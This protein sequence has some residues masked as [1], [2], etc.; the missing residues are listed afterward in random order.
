MKALMHK[1]V[2]AS[3][4]VA[5]LLALFGEQTEGA[6][7]PKA[8]PTPAAQSASRSAIPTMAV[9]SETNPKFAETFAD[10]KLNPEFAR[11]YPNPTQRVKAAQTVADQICKDFIVNASGG[12]DAQ[13]CYLDLTIT[14]TYTYD[15]SS[16][17]PAYLYHGIYIEMCPGMQITAPPQ[18][19]PATGAPWSAW[20][21][22]ATFGSNPAGS[23][24]WN[25]IWWTRPVNLFNNIIPSGQPLSLRLRIPNFCT[26]SSCTFKVQELTGFWAYPNNT[27]GWSCERDFTIPVISSPYSIGPDISVC[28]GEA[29]T[30]CIPNV[31]TGA[32]VTWYA[33]PPQGSPLSC[34]PANCSASTL[35]APWQVAQTGTSNCFNTNILT[36]SQCY[37]AVVNSGCIV[38]NTNVKRIDVCPGPPNASIGATPDTSVPA[39]TVINGVNHACTSWKGTLCLNPFT[40]P[41]PTTI[42]W[43]VNGN[44]IVI[45]P[46]FK[47]FCIPTGLLTAT[48]CSTPYTFQALLHNACGD[49]PVTWTIVIDKPPIPGAI[50]ANPPPPLCYDRATMLTLPPT[51]GQVVQWE[52]REELSPCSGNYGPWVAISGSQGTWTWWTN[53]LQK[54]TQYRVL[55]ENGACRNPPNP[56][57]YSQ[58]KIVTVKPPL[59][60][61]ITANKTVLCPPGGVILTAHSS[62]GPPCAYAVTYQWFKNGVFTG[63]TGATYSPTTGGNYYVVVNGQACGTA[64]SNV[65]TICD[66]PKL[67]ITG[68]CCVC[69]GETITLTANVLSTPQGCQVSCNN[70]TWNTGATG[71][72]IP[73]S[74]PGTYTVTANCGGCQLSASFTVSQCPQ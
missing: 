22:G 42:S 21:S 23:P 1:A 30:L 32:Q 27:N 48:A 52:N 47:P 55:V 35:P 64:K 31:P 74:Q 40:F 29:R 50:T 25:A 69:Q 70:Y 66:P 49:T 63:G 7:K 2:L 17:N 45:Q 71:P 54:T 10:P 43:S 73:V 14:H 36:Q 53:D 24:P 33:A 6:P 28:N 67:V 46:G 18:V 65:I 57:V 56:P 59:T 15:A 3:V 72:S 16:T 62:W 5:M 61:S 19:L 41:C 38:F 9:R 26:A 12:S 68:D 58:T 34:P 20:L 39:P 13:G 4:S 11:K 60:V 51:C 8:R 37:V 44:P